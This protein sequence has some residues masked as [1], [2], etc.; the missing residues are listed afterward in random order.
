MASQPPPFKLSRCRPYDWNQKQRTREWKFLSSIRL[1]DIPITDDQQK[2]KDDGDSPNN[3][4]ILNRESTDVPAKSIWER[5]SRNDNRL[6]KVSQGS[7]VVR[8]RLWNKVRLMVQRLVMQ[9]QPSWCC[10]GMR[11]QIMPHLKQAERNRMRRLWYWAN[12]NEGIRMLLLLRIRQL[13]RRFP[14][15]CLYLSPIPVARQS[16]SFVDTT[17]VRAG[18]MSR[19]WATLDFWPGKHNNLISNKYTKQVDLHGSVLRLPTFSKHCCYICRT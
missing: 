1:I 19:W 3:P 15:W 2:K 14:P 12:W 9:R 11:N 17:G 10:W 18:L 5:R 8:G 13:W 6:G 7:D 16:S 4:V